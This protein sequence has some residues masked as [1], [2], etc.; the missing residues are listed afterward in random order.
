M[1]KLIGL[2]AAVAFFASTAAFAQSAKVTAKVGSI[3]QVDADTNS[4]P[5]GLSPWHNILNN[6]LHTSQQ[7]DLFVSVSLEC[8]LLTDTTVR[9][10]NG[11]SDTSV[12][13]ASVQARVIVD[14]GT[15]RERIFE[16]G[17]INYCK[18]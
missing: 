4:S 5:S 16:P 10:K 3:I 8:G 11:T 12:A 18:R 6:T 13:A 1:K 14:Q 15:A 2:F 9:S 17:I 7:K